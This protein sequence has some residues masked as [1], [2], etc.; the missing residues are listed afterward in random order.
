MTNVRD[1]RFI[2][3][4]QNVGWNSLLLRITHV[5]TYVESSVRYSSSSGF[6]RLRRLYD[7][8]T[9]F[10]W[11]HVKCTQVRSHKKIEYFCLVIE[12]EGRGYRLN[13]TDIIVGVFNT[14]HSYY[15]T[16]TTRYLL[17]L[18][19]FLGGALINHNSMSLVYAAW[20]R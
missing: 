20:K 16:Y 3:R 6:V 17:L 9:Y 15:G 1:Y 4:L 10:F 13:N 2:T 14:L 5:Y 18:R 8:T 19:D 12:V 11:L 7:E